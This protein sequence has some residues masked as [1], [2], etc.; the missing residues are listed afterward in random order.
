LLSSRA[1]SPGNEPVS[2][3]RVEEIVFADARK[4]EGEGVDKQK[5]GEERARE[6][7]MVRQAARR[8]VVFGEPGGKKGE[9]EE[10]A[11][12]EEGGEKR[13]GKYEIVQGPPWKAVEGS[14]A[15]GEFWVRR[16]ED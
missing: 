11:G 13:G 1:P 8:L 9:E 14:F 2:T 4:E 15:K 16:M 12:R 5:T 10:G 3:E 7:E 6:R